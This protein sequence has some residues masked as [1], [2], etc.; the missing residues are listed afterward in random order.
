[1]IAAIFSGVLTAL[2]FPKF[3]LWWLAWVGLVPLF[4]AL[5]RAR[6]WRQALGLGVIFG[7]VFFGLNLFWVTS[8][9]RFV[10]GWAFFGWFCFVLFQTCFILLLIPVCYFVRQSRL[11]IYLMA[12][13]WIG[14]EWLRSLGPFGFT[15]GDLGYTQVPF[16]PIIQLA[17][18]TSVYGVSFIIV[19]VNAALASFWLNRRNW[20]K[21]AGAL[22]I[23]AITVVY[24]Y[25]QLS[26][27]GTSKPLPFKLALVQPNIDQLTKM[28]PG[29]VA[30]VFDIHDRLS[31]QSL[32][33]KPAVIIWPETAVFTYMINDNRFFPKLQQ[34]AA[35]SQAWL[36][37]GTPFYDAQS[38]RS[39]NSIVVLSPSGEVADRYDKEQLVPF[40]EYLPFR[41]LLFPL[42]KAVGYYDQDFNNNPRPNL[43]TVRGIK[44]APAICFESTFPGLIKERV[45]QGAEIILTITNNAWFGESAAAQLHLDNGVMRAVENRRYFIQVG[46][47]GLSAVVDPYGRILKATRL[48]ERAILLIP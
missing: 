13:A 27:S 8:L 3:G 33:E 12:V 5:F 22:L 4:Q 43:L 15:V 26:G 40:G 29:K 39:Y 41:P 42:L 20:P 18:L 44:I 48:N 1:M 45:K 36:V 25:W 10:G 21:L 46:N 30:E 6:N 32:S 34:L 31:R 47:N 35:D 9:A 11:N 28:S 37:L 19:L 23:V 14:V 17:A 24:G 16:L 38:N 2:A 7:L